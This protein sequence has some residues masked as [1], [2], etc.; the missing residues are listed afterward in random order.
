[1]NVASTSVTPEKPRHPPTNLINNDAARLYNYLHPLVVLSS[2]LLQF[3]PIV[4]NPVSSLTALLFPLNILQVVYVVLCL[5][6][7]RSVSNP[8]QTRPGNSK[9][10]RKKATTRQENSIATRTTVSYPTLSRKIL[11]ANIGCQSAILSLT[12]SL[13]LGTPILTLLA[14]L[15]GAPLTTHLPH[16]FLCAAHLSLLAIL[17]LVYVHGVEKDKWRAIVA[18]LLPIDDVYGGALGTLMGA[19]VGAV[20][21]PLDWCVPKIFWS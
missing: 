14:I 1:M 17:P 8:P 16:T 3:R 9:I 5:Q 21:I 2:Y 18:L 7:T 11:N 13:L 4:T 6:P 20:P 12:L 19:W 15:F 10:G